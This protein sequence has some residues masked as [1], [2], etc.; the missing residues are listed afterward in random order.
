LNLK[1]D[2]IYVKTYMQII[3]VADWKHAQPD[4]LHNDDLQVEYNTILLKALTDPREKDSR[5]IIKNIS[6]KNCFIQ[7]AFT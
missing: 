1:S 5:R 3:T 4:M 7:I 2:T 6:K